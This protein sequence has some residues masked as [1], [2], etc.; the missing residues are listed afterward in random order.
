MSESPLR[1]A[2]VG[3]GL[4][5][6]AAAVA[7]VGAGVNVELFEAR[8][9]LGGRAAS[10]DDED[11]PPVDYCQHVSMGCCTQLEQFCRTTGISELFR[12]DSTMHFIGPD[13]RQVDFA[14]TPGLPAPLHLLPGL[15]CMDF[16][17][18]PDRVQAARLLMRL[19]LWQPDAHS[20]EPTVAAWLAENRASPELTRRFFATVLVSALGET[21]DRAALSAARQVFLDGFL[22]SSAAGK[23][24]VPR[25]PL[26]EIFDGRV[27]AWLA[28]RG[29]AIHRS[30]PI[31]QVTIKDHRFASIQL[32]DGTLRTFDACVAAVP[33]RRLASIFA[34]GVRDDWP[35]L[36][37]VE[38][39][40]SAPITS[41][42]LW[43]DRPIT[44]LPHAV[45]IDRLSQWMFQPERLAAEADGASRHYVQVVVSGSHALA[46][47][48][49][50]DVRREIV[51]DLR[52]AFPAARAAQLIDSRLVTDPH[53]VF[54]VRPGVAS[55]RLPA[56]TP[57]AGLYLAGDWTNT[58]WPAT[59]EG[60]VRSGCLAADALLR[61]RQRPGV[62]LVGDLPPSWLA[63][64][65]FT[66]DAPKDVLAAS[67]R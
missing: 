8:R 46:A 22:R 49:K 51:D 57:F 36:A 52:A 65:M 25:V 53:A 3:G 5:G 47:R 48:E 58:G 11:G 15:L 66:F 63:R 24:R 62:S 42:H 40:A 10:F 32:A 35:E 4:A 55:S 29:V 23:L 7:L 30:T 37:Q 20:L 6:L 50:P 34:L 31:R 64:M 28:A 18:F 17:S 1:V 67:P 16:L 19:A 13:G 9:Q 14:A 60:A 2:I 56:P 41:A 33:W 12:E 43:F 54:S 61:D 26:R 38:Q 45:L 59:M 39:L 44:Q 21:L 27:G